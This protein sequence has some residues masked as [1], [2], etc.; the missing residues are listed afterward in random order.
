MQAMPS[1]RGVDREAIKT[2]IKHAVTRLRELEIGAA[3]EDMLHA[4]EDLSPYNTLDMANTDEELA[5]LMNVSGTRNIFTQLTNIFRYHAA[6]AV[7]GEGPSRDKKIFQDLV[8]WG[9]FIPPDKRDG[10]WNS[11]QDEA[12]QYMLKRCLDRLSVDD[13]EPGSTGYDEF[14]KALDH[15][16]LE[17]PE[18]ARNSNIRRWFDES[19]PLYIALHGLNEDHKIAALLDEKPNVVNFLISTLYKMTGLPAE[20]TKIALNPPLRVYRAMA[21][22]P[23]GSATDAGAPVSDTFNEE[24]KGVAKVQYMDR[25]MDRVLGELEPFF[26]SARPIPAR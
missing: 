24:A 11:V 21:P 14:Q 26:S 15:L 9:A 22:Y 8:A 1:Y 2:S 23:N 5:I 10:E 16:K 25:A 17:D 19:V 20:E 18:M 13:C 12:T 7:R 4:W 3:T 6:I